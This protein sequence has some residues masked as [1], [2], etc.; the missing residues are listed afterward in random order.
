MLATITDN[1]GQRP[2]LPHPPTIPLP[3]FPNIP[4]LPP[5][6]TRVPQRT[7]KVTEKFIDEVTVS[8]TTAFTTL[9]PPASPE[10]V[11]TENPVIQGDKVTNISKPVDEPTPENDLPIT[12]IPLIAIGGLVVIVA[13]VI[14]FVWKRNK[15]SKSSSKKD[16]MVSHEF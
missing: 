15:P 8:D 14:F 7:T 11:P 1:S 9:S 10:D 3:N 4:L 12:V 5:K 13:A 16:D 2:K 6:Y